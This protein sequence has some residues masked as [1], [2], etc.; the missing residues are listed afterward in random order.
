MNAITPFD[1]GA[2]EPDGKPSG[3]TVRNWRLARDHG[4]AHHW[5]D[6]DPVASAWFT[7]LSAGFPRGEA[8]FIE[9]VKAHRDGVDGKLAQDIRDFVRQEVNHSRE[10]LAF[11]RAAEASGYDLSAIDARVA[12]LVAMTQ[13][14]P[15]V[16]QLA[17]TSALEHFTAMFA[18]EFL[19]RP[20]H[21]GTSDGALKDLW[22]WHAVEE[23]EHK[24]VAF[25]TWLHATR[26]W[27]PLRRW[28]VR[29]VVM[30][31]VT[32][33][34]LRNRWVDALDLLA[35]DGITGLKAR[36]RLFAYLWLKPGILSRVFPAWASW[37]KPGFH[38]W[39]VDD[40][41]LIARHEAGLA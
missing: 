19:A 14:Q 2:G 16:I 28:F 11:N 9:A 10:H 23:I 31:D 21:F 17:I 6:G 38:P 25:D 22:R 12:G 18:H 27:T 37:F 20:E 30:G 4:V 26:A 33:R 35:Q 40:R 24:A 32:C 36:W 15:P 1:L 5:A 39:Q 3:L 8:M 7:C 34:F 41:A 13:Q 29:T